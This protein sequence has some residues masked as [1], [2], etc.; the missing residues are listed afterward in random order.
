MALIKF[1]PPLGPASSASFEIKNF[2]I[3]SSDGKG[4]DGKGYPPHIR[5]LW[6]PQQRD[7]IVEMSTFVPEQQIDVAKVNGTVFKKI[8]VDQPHRSVT[9]LSAKIT[10]L[11]KYLN[12]P[13][14]LYLHFENLI[15]TP[16]P[17]QS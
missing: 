10:R 3:G 11:T 12:E 8:M 6:L 4:S 9:M 1:D 15:I 2:Q 13:I 14:K 5:Q 7:A 17:T 16:K